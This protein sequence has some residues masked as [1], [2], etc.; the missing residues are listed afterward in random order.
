MRSHVG[1]CLLS[2]PS[3]SKQNEQQIFRLRKSS[4]KNLIQSIYF[5]FIIDVW[6]LPKYCW[7]HYTFIEKNQNMLRDR[8]KHYFRVCKSFNLKYG[9]FGLLNRNMSFSYYPVLIFVWWQIVDIS[10]LMGVLNDRI[11]LEEEQLILYFYSLF[12]T[13]ILS[14]PIKI[15]C[16]ALTFWVVLLNA[17]KSNSVRQSVT[18]TKKKYISKIL[19]MF[20]LYS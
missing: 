16:L 17:Y 9:W 12:L 13:V 18:I 3:S 19:K 10:I 4:L 20:F 11:Y 8:I 14:T 6:K 15:L 1:G 2:S 5:L 7:V